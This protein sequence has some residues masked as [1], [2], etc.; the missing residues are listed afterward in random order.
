MPILRQPDD[1]APL[2]QGDILKGLR[3]YITGEDW[4]GSTVPGGSPE[5]AEQCSFSMVI[6]RPCVLYHKPRIIV[7]AIDC[8]KGDVPE[9]LTTFKDVQAFLNRLRDGYGRPDRFYLGCIP[10][11]ER[12]RYFVQLDSLH[13]VVKPPEHGLRAFL[14]SNRVATLTDDFRRDLH[15]RVL[16]SVAN[17]G[18]DDYGWLSDEDLRWVLD[19]GNAE[20]LQKQM[21]L[22]EEKRKIA[23]LQASGGGKSPKEEAGREKKLEKLQAEVDEFERELGGYKDEFARRLNAGQ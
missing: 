10:G 6:S 12:G 4:S 22:A 18:F 8:V 14:K 15:L 16:A 3:L 23:E 19:A 2:N 20:L 21:Q 5:W 9:G 17:L 1:D 11:A 13:S 7:A